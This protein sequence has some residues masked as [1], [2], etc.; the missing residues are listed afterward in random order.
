MLN[1]YWN[2]SGGYIFELLDKTAHNIA[3]NNIWE[4][5]TASANISYFKE[6]SDNSQAKTNKVSIREMDNKCYIEIE[7]LANNFQTI[8]IANFTFIKKKLAI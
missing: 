1:K 3:V 6:I 2:L 5:V 7:L 4:C 8:A